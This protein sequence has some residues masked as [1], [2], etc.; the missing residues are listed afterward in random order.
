MNSCICCN[1]DAVNLNGIKRLLASGLGTFF[2]KGNPAF[3]NGPKSLPK[4]PPDYP[5]LCN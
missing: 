2:I 4:N 3:S 1:A 5:I